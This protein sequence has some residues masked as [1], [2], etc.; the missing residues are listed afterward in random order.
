ML[1]L[2]HQPLSGD[3]PV[4][5]LGGIQS[6]FHPCLCL[7]ILSG[8]EV[9][10]VLL[11]LQHFPLLD[12][13][14][15]LRLSGFPGPPP[16]LAAAPAPVPPAAAWPSAAHAAAGSPP[17]SRPSARGAQRHPAAPCALPGHRPGPRALSCVPRSRTP[18]WTET[19]PGSAVSST[20]RPKTHARERRLPIHH[21]PEGAH[22][23]AVLPV[24]LRQHEEFRRIHGGRGRHAP[25]L[26]LGR[27]VVAGFSAAHEE[28]KLGLR[29]ARP[30]CSARAAS[31]YIIN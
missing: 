9:F 24:T 21:I 25:D 27:R 26:G 5:A 29:A 18:A 6:F 11:Q 12:L 22:R 3:G 30:G 4:V 1:W 17:G 8:D 14:P 2:D 10:C 23:L 20:A 28:Q 7:Q 31:Q 19:R 15:G 16:P 13:G